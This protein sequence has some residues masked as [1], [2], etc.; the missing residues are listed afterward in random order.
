MLEPTLPWGS[1]VRAYRS[2]FIVTRLADE[3]WQLAEYWALR[4]Q[5]FANEQGLFQEADRDEHDD[6]ALPIVAMSTTAGMLDQ[7]VGTVRVYHAVAD[8]WFGG[9]LAVLPEYRRQGEVGTALIRTAVGGARGLGCRRFLA[10]VQEDNV[11]Y[12]ERH[13]FRVLEALTVRGRPHRLMEA[14]VSVFSVPAGFMARSLEA[15]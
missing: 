7:V 3:P 14:D 12:F 8:T 2:R 15:A 10:T 9:R 1:I 5:V 4:A 11:R 13:N 6:V